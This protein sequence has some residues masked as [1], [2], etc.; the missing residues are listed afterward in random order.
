MTKKRQSVQTTALLHNITWLRKKH[1]LSKKDMANLLQ[2]GVGSLTKIEK[3][4]LPLRLSTEVIF[5]VSNIFG[6]APEDL[7]TPLWPAKH[8]WF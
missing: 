3:G 8:P 4:E 5:R 6:I 7:F 1:N 2:I